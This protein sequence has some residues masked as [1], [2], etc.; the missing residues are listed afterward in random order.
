MKKFSFYAILAIGLIGI[1][2]QSCN[3]NKTVRL[4]SD[5]DSI[6][7]ILGS[8]WAMNTK[9]NLK[10]APGDALKLDIYLESYKK[11]FQEDTLITI[12]GMSLE[13]ANSYVS[14]YIQNAQNKASNNKKLEN[15]KFLAE[16][17]GKS[18]V[19]T[20]ESGLQYRVITEG[21]GPRPK[22]DDVVKVHYHGTLLDGTVFQSTVQSGQPTD[23]PLTA[24]IPGWTE[25]VQLMPVGSKYIFWIPMELGFGMNNPQLNQLLIFEIE[26]LEIVKQPK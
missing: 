10:A 23:I 22:A 12:L 1:A 15:D 18:G 20:T 7:Y 17:K 9:Q 24:V 3:S 14:A 21:K 4:E 8:F 13:E 2:F 16:N 19:I 26:L 6:S 5:V 25:G 11:A